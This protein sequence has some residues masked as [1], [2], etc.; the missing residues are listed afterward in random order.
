MNRPQYLASLLLAAALLI[1]IPKTHL[2][3]AMLAGLLVHEL[4]AV[5][6]PRV[7]R[8][9]QQAER[10]RLLVVAGIAATVLLILVLLVIGGLFLLRSGNPTALLQKMADILADT[11]S[12]LPEAF[13]SYL[14][15][16]T[17]SLKQAAIDWL[18]EHASE[19]QSVGKETGLMVAH[20]LIGMVVGALVSLRQVR[21]HRH[22]GPL[23]QALQERAFRFANAFRDVVFAQVTIAAIN[24]VF[25]ALYLAAVL[26]LFGIHLPLTKTMILLTFLFGLIPV[27]GNLASNT[28][29]FVV[30]L[31]HSPQVAVA[32]LLYLVVIHKLE[33][34]LNARIVGARIQAAAWELLLAML[35]MDA[36]FGIPGVILAPIYYAYLKRELSAA[37][38]I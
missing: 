13:R 17:D 31:S 4:V 35:L 28:V 14:P 10:A 6:A 2:L 1:L 30:S 20:L 27:L 37:G 16:G 11:R 21:S 26:P 9:A 33:Y 25:T 15:V 8:G 3:P 12:M 22:V 32:S 19:L 5:L 34:F 29:I 7:L 18:R 36:L 23:A 24:A 38:Q